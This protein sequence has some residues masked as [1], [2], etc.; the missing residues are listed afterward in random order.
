M[1]LELDNISVENH[2]ERIDMI[3]EQDHMLPTGT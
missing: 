2:T 1:P 3:M